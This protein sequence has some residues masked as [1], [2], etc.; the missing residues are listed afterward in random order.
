MPDFAIAAS[1]FQ[2][3]DAAGSANNAGHRDDDRQSL[4][5]TMLLK[6]MANGIQLLGIN[7]SVGLCGIANH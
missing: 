6:V 1:S 5:W 4:I 7:M 2:L 3:G